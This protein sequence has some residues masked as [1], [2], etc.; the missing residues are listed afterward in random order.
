MM[1]KIISAVPGIS[2][3]E[4]EIERFLESN[5]N[6]QLATLEEDNYPNINQVWF[7]YDKNS[8]KIYATTHKESRKVQ[9]ILKNPDKIYFSIDDENFYTEGLKGV[10][11]RARATIIFEDRQK[12]ISVEE[13]IILKYLGTL[14]D[15][16]AKQLMENAADGT[17]VG[18][19]I[20]P[21]FFSAYVL[22][23]MPEA[24]G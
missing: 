12:V 17:F 15:P 16:W 14:E 20:A 24:R 21:K 11:G 9:N 7:Y 22:G 5:L 19:E 18:I 2:T 13:K 23:N 3:T 10:K 6:L 1:T 8:G 4:T